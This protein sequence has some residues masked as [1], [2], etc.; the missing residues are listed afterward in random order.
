[1]PLTSRCPQAPTDVRGRGLTAAGGSPGGRCSL[2]VS[3]PCRSWAGSECNSR[4]DLQEA[5]GTLFLRL[6]QTYW[7]VWRPWT[8]LKHCALG[9]CF[10]TTP[11]LPQ[12]NR[13]VPCFFT[14]CGD[15]QAAIINV[16]LYFCGKSLHIWVQYS[17]HLRC[18]ESEKEKLS[19]IKFQWECSLFM[20]CT[21]GSGLPFDFFFFFLC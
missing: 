13:N 17:E 19:I 14:G 6:I 9:V 1:M 3:Q 15:P 18:W 11:K 5:P 4:A 16:Y 12:L 2:P 20:P 21:T 7:V 8:F 10:E